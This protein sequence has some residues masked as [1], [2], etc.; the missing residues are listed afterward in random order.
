MASALG[1]AGS[2][3]ARAC[4]SCN[5]RAPCIPRVGFSLLGGF[6]PSSGSGLGLLG[7]LVSLVL[8]LL[9]DM[10]RIR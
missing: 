9:V 6:S 10:S 5:W 1:G 3:D 2:L 7:L 8:A 4:G